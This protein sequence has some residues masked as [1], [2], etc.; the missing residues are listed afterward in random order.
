MDYVTFIT[1]G[2]AT[3][4]FVLGFV[5]L[6]SSKIYVNP[7]TRAKLEVEIPL[8]GKMQSNYP[9][10]LFVFIGAALAVYTIGKHFD[11]EKSK[12]DFEKTKI[13]TAP[14]ETIWNIHGQLRQPAGNAI[15]MREGAKLKLVEYGPSFDIWADGRFTIQVALP[16]G[17]DF[18]DMVDQIAYTSDR[19]TALIFPRVERE[20]FAK[21]RNSSKLKEM[22]GKTRVYKPVDVEL[23]AV[24]PRTP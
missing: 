19:A 21:D 17:K 13:S 11:F 18:E 23:I 6:L 1:L 24:A 10:L 2:L 4:S 20:A 5:A 15:D 22:P 7:K 14:H 8:L 9:A 16:E 3:L 12:L